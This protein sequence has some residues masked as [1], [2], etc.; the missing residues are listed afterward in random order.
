MP[1]W[2]RFMRQNTKI[3][4]A[5]AAL[6][7]TAVACAIGSG[8]VAMESYQASRAAQERLRPFALAQ[9]ITTSLQ[10]A[11]D[12]HEKLDRAWPDD[13]AAVRTFE[14]AH[15]RPL[16][17]RLEAAQAVLQADGG[18]SPTAAEEFVTMRTPVPDPAR[19]EAAE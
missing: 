15:W 18:P 11:L 13:W 19:S 7:L 14:S 5:A 16:Q 12:A 10:Q 9:E 2:R 3:L 4:R 6:S 8:L 1:R 17:S